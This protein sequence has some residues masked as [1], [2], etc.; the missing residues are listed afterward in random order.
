[1]VTNAN[2]H[3]ASPLAMTALTKSQLLKGDVADHCRIR[4]EEKWNSQEPARV[5]SPRARFV[6]SQTSP[7]GAREQWLE[8][9]GLKSSPVVT[10]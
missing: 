8:V 7:A 10:N 6:A 1:L 4:Q 3:A 9:F 2:A 5:Q